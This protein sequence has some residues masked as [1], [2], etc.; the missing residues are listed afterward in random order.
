MTCNHRD[1][2]GS[3]N[4]E[5]F[6]LHYS[7][8][9]LSCSFLQSILR[10]YLTIGSILV[11]HKSMQTS[12]ARSA[13]FSQNNKVGIW[14]IRESSHTFCWYGSHFC[15]K[16]ANK[17]K[18]EGS[19]RENAQGETFS[20]FYTHRR[21]GLGNFI[22]KLIDLIERKTVRWRMKSLRNTIHN[23]SKSFRISSCNRVYNSPIPSGQISCDTNNICYSMIRSLNIY[24]AMKISKLRGL[25]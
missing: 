2:C 14:T 23:L 24:Y 9:R 18:E 22:N 5:L 12:N 6:I 1:L 10:R 20:S 17:D 3:T 19:H 15:Q 4:K 21:T 16:N 11:R 7:N 25:S 13:S 8:A